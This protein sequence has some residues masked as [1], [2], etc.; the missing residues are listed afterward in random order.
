MEG[1]N[2]LS[3]KLFIILLTLLAISLSIFIFGI[4]YQNELPKLVEEINN[5]TIGGI[6]TAIITV[7]L[8]QGQTA[9]EEE[10]ERSVK[11]F[12]EKSQ[13]FNEFTN[14]LWKIWEDRSV[15]LEEL[16]VLMKS[17]AQNIIPYA[18]PENSQKILAS[19]NKIADKATPNQ[20]DSNNEQITNEIQK[21]IFAIINIL[22]GEI[23]LG[24]TINDSMRT[25]LDKLEK[26]ITPYLNRK[27][28]FDKVNT[29]LFEKSKGYIHSF[30][31]EN[32]ILWWKIGEDTGVWLRIGEWG[33]E[34]N[35]Y[36]AFWSDYSN[37]QYHPYRYAS[38]G[39]DK[40]FLGAEGYR[41]LYKMLATFSKEEFYQ[42]LEGKTMSSQKIVDFE[43][44]II[45]F[46]NGDEN[47]EKTIKDIIKECNN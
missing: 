3:S 8:L 7:L 31:E 37:A 5:S 24:G 32:N 28:Y 18:K 9:S 16:T 12:E 41:Y 34:K 10:K 33:K 29:T 36:L 40:H 2:I 23:G 47:Q 44:E 26:K 11:V 30:Q 13:K 22:S 15:S 21:E 14:E 25:D 45:D 39:E 6:L 38:R 43:K 27:N 20:S 42:L 1:K 4:I 17:V 19:L 35:I 46:Y